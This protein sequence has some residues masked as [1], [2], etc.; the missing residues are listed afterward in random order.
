MHKM[1]IS[2]IQKKIETTQG[3]EKNFYEAMLIDMHYD[4]QELQQFY[5]DCMNEDQGYVRHG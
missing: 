5:L 1:A 3:D 4:A 2:E